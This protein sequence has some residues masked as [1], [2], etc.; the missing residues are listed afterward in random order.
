MNRTDKESFVE[1]FREQVEAAPVVYLTDFTGL[2]VKSITV[3]RQRLKAAGAEYLVV[4]NRLMRRALEYASTFELPLIDHCEDLSLSQG[5]AI[6]EGD[7]AAW[8]G[9]SAQPAS[10][11][12][13]MLAR[14]L[15]LCG[16]TGARFHAAHVSTAGSVELI[17]RAKDQGLPI[18]AAIAST[19]RH[20]SSRRSS[21][22]WTTALIPRGMCI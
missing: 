8:T 12:E 11:E 5:G 21:L 22:S 10:A 20:S 14:D 9:L 3:L 17:R 18:T 7:V 16:E 13:V 6:H 15:T 19:W 2:D 4:K 1:S